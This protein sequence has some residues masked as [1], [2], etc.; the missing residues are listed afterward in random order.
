MSGDDWDY[1]GGAGKG[2]SR[3][4]GCGLVST[5]PPVGRQ[6]TTP[7]RGETHAGGQSGGH[8]DAK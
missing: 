2:F 6:D 3:V 7:L 4:R 5:G 8:R 1:N